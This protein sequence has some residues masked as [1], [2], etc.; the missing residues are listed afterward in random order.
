MQMHMQDSLFFRWKFYCGYFPICVINENFV[1]LKWKMSLKLSSKCLNNLLFL[2][3][4]IL[5]K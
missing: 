3:G 1:H 4:N 5:A 2:K